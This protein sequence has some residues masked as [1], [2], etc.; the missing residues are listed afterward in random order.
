MY[1]NRIEALVKSASR[2]Q[3]D[4]IEISYRLD[5]N[6]MILESNYH[7]ELL[8]EYDKSRAMLDGL[9]CRIGALTVSQS[10]EDNE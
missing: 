9:H 7:E 10:T 8:M 5:R 1:K 3:E 2:L 6:D 4:L